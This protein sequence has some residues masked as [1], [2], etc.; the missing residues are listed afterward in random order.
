[1]SEKLKELNL[2]AMGRRIR[3]I[4]DAKNMT[5]ETFAE[6][7]DL[8]PQ[9]I[10]D[11]E[12]GNKG[13]SIR[14]LYLISQVLGVSADYLLAGNLYSIDKD[15]EAARVC[16]DIVAILQ[17]C[18]LEQLKDFRSISRIYADNVRMK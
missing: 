6:K 17:T 14:N 9:F 18:S 4:R 5:R 11:I 12:Y 13:V 3:T 8:S 2:E 16:E 10:A 15:S 1:M 7:V